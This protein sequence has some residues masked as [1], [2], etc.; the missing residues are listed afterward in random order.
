MERLLLQSLREG[1]GHLIKEKLEKFSRVL[2]GKLGVCLTLASQLPVIL[3]TQI[4][5]NWTFNVWKQRKEGGE[6]RRI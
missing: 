6:R 3:G 4:E 5:R 2:S 1:C